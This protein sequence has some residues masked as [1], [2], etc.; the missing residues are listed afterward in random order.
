M[1]QLIY[2]LIIIP[3]MIG[4]NNVAKEKASAEKANGTAA[5]PVNQVVG[6]GK[7][8]P[9]NDI[10]QLS[11]EVSGVVKQIKKDENDT[12]KAGE[13]VLEL[14][15]T[16][17]DAK[18]KQLSD[19]VGTQTAQIKSDEASLEEFQAKYNNAVA[20]VQRLQKLLDKGAETQQNVDDANTNLK[21]YQSNLNRLQ[22][23]VQVSQSKLSETKAALL[24]SQRER[25]QKIIRSPVNGKILEIS[26]LIGGAVDSK[27]SF[28]QISPEGKTIAVCEIDELFADKIAD[29]Q[30]AWVRN[31]GSPDTLSTGTV[32]FTASFLKKKSLFTDQAG[33]KEDRRVR[34]IKIMLDQPEKLLLNARVE[35][36]VDISA[37]T[38][39]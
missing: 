11:S 10:I 39:K 2:F 36:V 15:H 34:E 13:T 14:D 6:I 21:S 31:L 4:C 29:G 5:Q 30:K 38:K 1:K 19:Q 28:A 8:E 12:V 32:Y 37:N 26:T 25:D 23:N 9:E 24:V 22:A 18:I 7:I 20:Q 3:L 17:D 35:C 27:Q 33:E 16:V